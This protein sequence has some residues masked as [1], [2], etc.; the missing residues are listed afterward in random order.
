MITNV[1][2]WYNTIVMF[3]QDSG[4]VEELVSTSEIADRLGIHRV[5]AAALVRSGRVPSIKVANRWLVRRADLE[6]FART[7]D[8]RRGRPRKL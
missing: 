8:G 2:F 3:Y 7:Y 1:I 5:A 6:Q 4:P